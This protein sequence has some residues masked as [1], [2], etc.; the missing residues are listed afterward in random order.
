MTIHQTRRIENAAILCHEANRGYCESIGDTT[1]VPWAAAPQWQKDSAIAGVQKIHD[2]PDTT[3]EQSHEG[4]MAQ[5]IADGWI[6]GLEKDPEKKHHPCIRPYRELEPQQR[7][8]DAI[9]G[10]VARGALYAYGPREVR[11]A[12]TKGE[13]T[14]PWK[15]TQEAFTFGMYVICGRMGIVVDHAM[16]AM[17]REDGYEFVPD[18]PT[19]KNFFSEQT[20]IAMMTIDDG[21]A[22]WLVAQAAHAMSQ[23]PRRVSDS[24]FG[25]AQWAVCYRIVRAVMEI[26]GVEVM[27]GSGWREVGG[28]EIRVA[29][30]TLSKVGK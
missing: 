12:Q 15:A 4:W 5:K 1:Q 25:R 3:P 7:M 24:D 21:V 8:K 26:E 17:D 29:Y 9:F 30:R 6:W 10:G 18:H 16:R 19:T 20:D 22:P 11:L 14:V 2:D 23:W 27:H 28:R 13:V